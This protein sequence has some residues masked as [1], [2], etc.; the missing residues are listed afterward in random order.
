MKLLSK[1]K[2]SLYYISNMVNITLN[3]LY[4]L[5]LKDIKYIK[6]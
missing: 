5:F 6:D 3:K 4:S 1:I 2:F